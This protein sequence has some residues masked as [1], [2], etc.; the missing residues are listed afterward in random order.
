VQLNALANNTDQVDRR[1][2]LTALLF[3]LLL[4][5]FDRTALLDPA[6]LGMPLVLVG[7]AQ[8][9]WSMNN[10]SG[11]LAELFDAGVLIG[12][13]GLFYLPYLFLV[14]VLWA[15]V[16]VMRPFELARIHASGPG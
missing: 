4:A 6:L 7:L 1:N 11:A 15:S 8:R 5:A 13:A 14:V 3:V 12:L 16:S 2:H 9:T 10:R